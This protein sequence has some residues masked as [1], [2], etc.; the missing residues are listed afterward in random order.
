M[1]IMC[2]PL[3]QADDAK[4]DEIFGVKVEVDCP[5]CRRRVKLKVPKAD[6]DS[7]AS[8]SYTCPYCHSEHTF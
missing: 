8:V 3:K 7:R 4:W 1:S 5:T 6:Y 2:R